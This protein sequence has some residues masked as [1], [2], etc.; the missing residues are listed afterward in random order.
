MRDIKK[1]N[2]GL[3]VK[4]DDSN[5]Y[6]RRSDRIFDELENMI[7]S[8]YTE[9]KM[10]NKLN[11]IVYKLRK[12]D[13]KLLNEIDLIRYSLTYIKIKISKYTIKIKNYNDKHIRFK[14]KLLARV[15]ILKQFHEITNE[16]KDISK[17]NQLIEIAKEHNLNTSGAHIQMVRIGFMSLYELKKKLLKE[18]I[19]MEIKKLI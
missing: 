15:N 5:I 14:N 1:T 9:N 16:I 18:I 13:P 7:K 11:I 2:Y 10:K 17:L 3:I 8:Y 19:K 12:G 6:N 4:H